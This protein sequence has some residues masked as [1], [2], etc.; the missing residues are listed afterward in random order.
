MKKLF[1]HCIEIGNDMLQ[2]SIDTESLKGLIMEPKKTF[3]KL[4]FKRTNG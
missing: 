3:K 4:Y 2:N 1:S